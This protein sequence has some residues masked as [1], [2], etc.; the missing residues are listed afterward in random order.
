[1]S[2]TTT[3][4][5]K[6]LKPGQFV[7]LDGEVCKVSSVDVSKSGKH[8]AAKAR[9]EAL[10]LFDGKRR[11]LVKPA[12]SEVEVPIILKKTAQIL[13][14]YGDTAQLMDMQDYSQFEA[15]IP[16]DLK[17]E[18]KEGVEVLYW[19]IVGKKIIREVKSQQ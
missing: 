1:M 15:P 16:D 13:S 9:L 19:E 10:G 18:V 2:E 4:E 7:I 8:G 5:L 14:L 17:G 11:T 6:S 12:D 3:N